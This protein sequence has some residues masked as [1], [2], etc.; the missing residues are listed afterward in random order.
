MRLTQ[1]VPKADGGDTAEADDQ[2]NHDAEQCKAPSGECS[3]LEWGPQAEQRVRQV[4][5][6]CESLAG[7]L[8][9]A[10]Q[11][12]ALGQ[13]AQDA[14]EAE[15]AMQEG[16]LHLQPGGQNEALIKEVEG[17]R[18]RTRGHDRGRGVMR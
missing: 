2:C 7:L 18:A 4:T 5:P 12:A 17:G 9:V 13:A 16:G 3:S 1:V 14:K 6:L 15:G 11:V 10:K 8:R